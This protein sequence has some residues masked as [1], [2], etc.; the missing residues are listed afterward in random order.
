MKAT[1]IS[2]LKQGEFFKMKPTESAPVWVRGY[3]VREGKQYECYRYDNTNRE[4]FRKGS[5]IVYTD[6]ES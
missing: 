3:Y 1:T 4:T 6:F 2:A 5:T